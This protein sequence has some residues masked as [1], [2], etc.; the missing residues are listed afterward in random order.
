M[1]ENILVISLENV[2]VV[3]VLD[4]DIPL[5]NINL[6]KYHACSPLYSIYHFDI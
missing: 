3:Y 2:V 5:E 4:K 6:G 1:L